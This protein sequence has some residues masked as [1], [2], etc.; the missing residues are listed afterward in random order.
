PVPERWLTVI[1]VV[2]D[3]RQSSLETAA[4]AE[5]YMPQRQYPALWVT[6]REMVIRADGAEPLALAPA[7]RDVIRGVDRE[8]PIVQI[9][10]LESVIGATLTTR[11][12]QTILFGGFAAL[13]L[14]L[15]S[16]GLYGV[17]S[18]AVTRR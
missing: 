1:G 14:A 15:A 16:I 17:L 13:G 2:A 3:A 5:M 7:V 6:P 10:T 9:R 18:Y 11:R 8:Q 4:K 12:L